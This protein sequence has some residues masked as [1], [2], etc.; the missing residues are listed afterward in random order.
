MAMKTWVS[1]DKL[2]YFW[3]ILKGK[4]DAKVDKISG[5]SLSESD[6][7]A[8]EKSKL[9]G[10]AAG[11]T[12]VTVDAALSGTSANAI[13]N[14]AVKTALDGKA[15]LSAVTT[16]ANGLMIAADKTKLDGVAANAQVNVIEGVKVNGATLTPSGKLVSITVPTDV[17]TAAELANALAP[18]AKTAVVPTKVSQLQNDSTYQTG[19][20][21]SSSI[22]SAIAGVTTFSFVI[23][24]TLPTADQKSNHIYLLP[25]SGASNDV[26]D[27]WAWINAKWEHI[28]QTDVDLSGY[29]KEAEMAEITNAEID[30][31][32][33]S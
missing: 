27:E 20:Q 32:F 17:T 25:K 2:L 15:S 10:I 23:V 33:A 14:K 5:K 26:Y 13:Q 8:A 21:V 18:Y 24:A 3:Q 9:S 22:N 1:K 29:V 11:A 31:I 19:A 30:T 7:T 4:L 12:N 6:F 28:G 16:S